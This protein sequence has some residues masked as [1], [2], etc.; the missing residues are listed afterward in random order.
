MSSK[1][2][3]RVRITKFKLRHCMYSAVWKQ[4]SLYRPLTKSGDPRVWFNSITKH[5]AP[6]DLLGI[7]HKGTRLA[8]INCSQTN[9]SATLTNTGGPLKDF[10]PSKS[11]Q[12]S[13]TASELLGKLKDIS[14]RG[15]IQTMRPHDTGVGFTLETLLGIKANSSK[16]PDFKGIEIKSARQRS[17]FLEK[18]ASSKTPNWKLQSEGSK[19]ILESGENLMIKKSSPIIHE[20]S[21][22]APN[23]YG[24]QLLMNKIRN[25][26]PA[27][28][29][30]RAKKVNDVSWELDT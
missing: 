27:F 18:T 11:S 9:L 17:K 13:G 6:N 21:A 1:V 23:S 25:A 8:V 15:F 4:A 20:I 16:A 22:V 30:G 19:D 7:I 5:C 12:L 26:P 29:A 28:Q 24:L 10:L 3:S 14:S 2:R